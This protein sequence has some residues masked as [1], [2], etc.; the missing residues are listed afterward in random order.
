MA[1]IPY[2]SLHYETKA[3]L[4]NSE[5]SYPYACKFVCDNMK[6]K[7]FDISEFY[8]IFKCLDK[9]LFKIRLY[10]LSL[11]RRFK[12]F[13][14]HNLVENLI[15]KNEK[16]TQIP[17][18]IYMNNVD[19]IYNKYKDLNGDLDFLAKNICFDI[20][21][22]VH[23]EYIYGMKNDL[24]VKPNKL[25]EMI[26][27]VWKTNK[28]KNLKLP[29]YNLELTSTN[30]FHGLHRSGWA[31]TVDIL[32]SLHSPYGPIM[33]VYCDAT[34][35][36][37]RENPC[38]YQGL[39]PY[40]QPWCGFFHHTPD[41]GYT[42]NN[43]ENSTNNKE[44]IQSLETCIGLFTL[45]EWLANW[46]RI[47]LKSYGYSKIPVTVVYHPTALNVKQFNPE[48]LKRDKIN[49]I[50]VGAWMRNS[51]SIYALKLRDNFIKKRL[52]GKYM[53]G[54][55]PSD[56]N[57]PFNYCLEG[58]LKTHDLTKDEISEQIKSVQVIEYLSNS[59]YDDLLSENILF[60]EFIECS[61]ANSIIECMARCCPIITNRLDSIVEYLGKDY[62]LY[63]DTLDEVYDLATV[64]NIEKAYI[65][66][67][68]NPQ[69]K[70]KISSETFFNKVIK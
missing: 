62:P 31:F 37:C 6:P 66:M 19:K 9:D 28:A 69:L 68:D 12:L 24:L 29:A 1:G 3:I 39:I 2:I 17:D 48:I 61:A 46:L 4:Y 58:Y 27:W 65:Y 40:T 43:I 70:N 11:A 14:D 53:D 18:I 47:R 44:F 34:F 16:R 67:R 30:N 10:L 21:N 50:N 36:W 63:F 60:I 26:D 22:E 13:L 54:Y 33:D 64:E 42:N 59:E 15:V 25:R 20:T 51:Y 41:G 45:S 7:S 52:R 5:N 49:V 23:S 8:N 57:T 55:F 32:K 35:G 38:K 56:G